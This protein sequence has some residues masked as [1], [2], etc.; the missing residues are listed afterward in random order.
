MIERLRTKG[1]LTRDDSGS[2]HLY[3]PSEPKN[4]LMRGLVGDFVNKALGGSLSPFMAYLG[5]D[6]NLTP[7]ELEELKQLVR[8]LD[9]RKEA[10]DE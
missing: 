5:N 2:V 7:E 8:T 1:Y 10:V 6:A 9:E 4:D 3:S